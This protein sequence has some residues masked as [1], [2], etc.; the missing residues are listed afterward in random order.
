MSFS[1]FTRSPTNTSRSTPR[2]ICPMSDVYVSL[3]GPSTRPD[4]SE[5]QA[6]H[7]V[8]RLYGVQVTSISE[9]NSYYDRNFHIVINDKHANPYLGTVNPHGYVFKILNS[10][11]SQMKHVGEL[12][13]KRR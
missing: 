11:D 2:P 8:E 4:L 1:S 10:L 6:Q 9:L 13:R 5:E 7:I 3:P 12:S